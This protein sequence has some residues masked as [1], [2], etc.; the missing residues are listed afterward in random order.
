M[1]VNPA[2]PIGTEGLVEKIDGRQRPIFNKTRI[3]DST[4]KKREVC[5]SS[6]TP[7][8]SP[9]TCK[10]SDFCLSKTEKLFAGKC[11]FLRLHANVLKLILPFSD[12]V[13]TNNTT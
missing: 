5:L 4:L 1:G 11:A 10:T 7:R 2:Y 12:S 9:P 8:G 3:H 13:Q 6:S